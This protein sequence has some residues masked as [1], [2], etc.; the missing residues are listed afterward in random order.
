MKIGDFAS[1][2]AGYPK[3]QVEVVAPTNH[4]SAQKTLL[5]DLSYGIKI[6]AE[7]SSVLSQCTCLT[8]GQTAFS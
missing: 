6:W 5:N 4:S 2:E 1:V 7:L 3:F 8:D